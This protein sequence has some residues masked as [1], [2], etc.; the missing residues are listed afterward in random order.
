M[1][2]HCIFYPNGNTMVFDETGEQV[3]RIQEPWF[4]LYLTY[5]ESKDIDPT[6][7]K[8]SIAKNGM[9]MSYVPFKTDAGTWN[10]SVSREGAGS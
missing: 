8:F 6:S 10:W 7:C 2:L 5:L 1:K 9:I 3:P 4:K